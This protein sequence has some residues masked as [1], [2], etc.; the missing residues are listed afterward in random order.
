MS[1]NS[2]SHQDFFVIRTPRMPVDEL[3]A[4]GDTEQQTRQAL[5]NWIARPEVKE[6]LYLASPSLLE[7]LQQAESGKQNHKQRKKL[8][9]AL[10]KYMIRMCSRPTP[11]G[12]FS[13]IHMGK[14]G[15]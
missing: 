7:R 6:A 12:L 15:S 11:F 5:D 13:G 10:L 9:Q 2:I 8:E 3:L 1:K 14:I 4:L